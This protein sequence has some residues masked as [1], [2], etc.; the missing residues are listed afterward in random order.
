MTTMLP[1]PHSTSYRALLTTVPLMLMMIPT[2]GLD[3]ASAQTALTLANLNDMTWRQ[4]ADSEIHQIAN[5][6]SQHRIA[7]QVAPQTSSP[8]PQQNQDI[9]L[10]VLLNAVL[11]LGI[12]GGSM[13]LWLFIAPWWQELLARR[14]EQQTLNRQNPSSPQP[15][16]EVKQQQSS[17]LEKI[18]T[19]LSKSIP[20]RVPEDQSKPVEI[21]RDTIVP[22]AQA[23]DEGLSQAIAQSTVVDVRTIKTQLEQLTRDIRNPQFPKRLLSLLEQNVDEQKYR[24]IFAQTE[25]PVLLAV[26]PPR[27]ADICLLVI[28]AIVIPSSTVELCK[29]L[30]ADK[31][32]RFDFGNFKRPRYHYFRL[33]E[34][35]LRMILRRGLKIRSTQSKS[36]V[37]DT[38]R[39]K[40][41]YELSDRLYQGI[42]ACLTAIV[43]NQT[44]D[45]YCIQRFF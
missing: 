44:M 13:T 12:L 34:N 22:N 18:H 29:I 9:Q 6:G 11:G 45:L 25:L 24:Q 16:I 20:K 31:K 3:G 7:Q 23:H 2:R 30:F 8:Q 17:D 1:R 19:S 43:N 36:E 37:S 32:S 33:F 35:R 10:T 39:K 4:P 15:I 14:K 28:Q 40:L 41:S 21:A 26:E 42:W 38:V 27:Q 5:S